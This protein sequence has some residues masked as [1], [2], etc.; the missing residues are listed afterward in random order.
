[1]TDTPIAPETTI[2]DLA[3]TLPG[4]A[5]ILR[6]AG[7]GFCCGGD[8]SLQQAAE[9]AGVDPS[10]LI[11]RL[12]DSSSRANADAPQDFPGLIDHILTR[13]HAT[14]RE[15]LDTLVPLAERVERVHGSHAEAPLGLAEALVALRDDLESHMVKEE[16]VLFPAILHGAGAKMAGPIRVMTEEHADTTGILA[17]IEHVTHGL[18]LPEDACGS[19]SALYAGLR[20]LGDDVVAHIHLEETNLF[21]RALAS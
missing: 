5:A 7:I 21:P 6:D 11:A 15:E 1:M 13:Y 10:A 4:A 14:H 2:R 12:R 17:R 3:A 8:L 16:R 18:R 20:K 19:W 9:K